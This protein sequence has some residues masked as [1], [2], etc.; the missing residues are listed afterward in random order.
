MSAASEHRV[1]FLLQNVSH[2]LKK[3]ADQLALDSGGMTT[4]QAGVLNIIIQHGSVS[5]AQIAKTLSQR[6][7]ATATMAARLES[8]GYIKKERSQEDRRAW[9]LTPTRRGR[10]AQA[11][12]RASLGEVNDLL[13]KTLSKP[14]MDEFADSL[15]KILAALDSPGSL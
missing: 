4:A 14:K 8:A 12:M 15:K 1:Y 13:N 7:S 2:R 11:K 9:V 6:E 5:Q 3:K 10:N